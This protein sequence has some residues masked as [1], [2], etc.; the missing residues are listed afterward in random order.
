MGILKYKNALF[1]L[2][3]GIGKR[4]QYYSSV[5][6]AQIAFSLILINSYENPDKVQ[7][8]IVSIRKL[9]YEIINIIYTTH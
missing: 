3:I 5:K 9:N 7:N 1:S 8:Q 4:C 6:S 2:A